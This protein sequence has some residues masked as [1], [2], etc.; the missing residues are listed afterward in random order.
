MPC[1]RSTRACGCIIP[2][3]RGHPA[4]NSL[5]NAEVSPSLHNV[6]AAPIEAIGAPISLLH[7]RPGMMAQRFSA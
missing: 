5:A 2:E 6:S 3:R 1:R 4:A 7:G